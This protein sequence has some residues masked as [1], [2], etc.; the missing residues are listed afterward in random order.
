MQTRRL[1]QHANAVV[2]PVHRFRLAR[3]AGARKNR[4]LVS[5]GPDR[6]SKKKAAPR[7]ALPRGVFAAF[8]SFKR[9]R[10][11]EGL[12]DISRERYLR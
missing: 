3:R 7:P 6:V 12:I 5:K 10:E 2:L 4:G 8:R 11:N 1:R 9:R